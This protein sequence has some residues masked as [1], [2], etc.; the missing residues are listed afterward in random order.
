MKV[1][2]EGISQEDRYILMYDMHHI[3]SDGVSRKILIDEF[4]SLYQGKHLEPLRLQYKD[5]AAW[6]NEL[7]E[8]E[9][10]KLQ[11]KYWLEKF[12]GDI[13]VIN[14][15]TDFK[16]PDIK[17]FSGNNI[18][19]KAGNDLALELKQLALETGTTLYMVLLS[20]YKV[21]LSRYSGQE[22]LIVGSPIAGRPHADL[23]NIIGMFVNMISIRS[24]P[25]GDKTFAELLEEVR[26]DCLKAYENQEYQYEELVE[27][28]SVKRD[29]SRNPLFDVSFTLQ[30]LD[31]DVIDVEGLKFE[32]YKFESSVS[33]FDL[34][35]WCGEAQ[36]DIEFIMEYCTSL[37]KKET[38]ERMSQDYLRILECIVKDAE[39][40]IKDIKL[41]NRY[42]KREKVLVKDVEFSF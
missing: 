3:I 1:L 11:E 30:N 2:D 34:T 38:I 8:S 39:I 13:P 21:L 40:K 27:K 32:P 36:G 6:Q 28:L 26:E 35:L 24:F 18:S 5:F 41:G 10:I 37:F 16:R 7:F 4:F 22:D 33:K 25:A 17:G 23:E 12:K 29:M 14:L 31:I 15:P 19:F 20:A 42:V 9:E